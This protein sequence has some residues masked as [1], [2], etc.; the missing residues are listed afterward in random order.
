MNFKVLFLIAALFTYANA[1]AFV[2]SYPMPKMITTR[3]AAKY[4]ANRNQI[5]AAA[6]KRIKEEFHITDADWRWYMDYVAD[7]I[8][9]DILFATYPLDRSSIFPND[10]WL[11]QE[12]KEI[13]IQCGIDPKKI[14]ISLDRN[15]EVNAYTKQTDQEDT[16]IKH[17]LVL[18]PD[19]LGELFPQER[20]SMIRH[21]IMHFAL[22]DS[23]EEGFIIGLL[24]K[25]GHMQETIEN[26]PAMINYRVTRE[27]RADILSVVDNLALAKITQNLYAELAQNTKYLPPDYWNTHPSY[28]LRAQNFTQLLAEINQ[29]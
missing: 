9:K 28:E 29:R 7:I 15:P 10:H 3:H 5:H 12:A 17:A 21:E 20:E 14:E 24:K 22:Y 26:N 4:Y 16:T 1:I 23:L 25:N 18:N 2:K 13:L 6:L 27:T 19:W 11:I 8:K